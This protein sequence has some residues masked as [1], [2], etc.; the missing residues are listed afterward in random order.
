LPGSP[1]SAMVRPGAARQASFQPLIPDPYS[2]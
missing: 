1:C 2:N